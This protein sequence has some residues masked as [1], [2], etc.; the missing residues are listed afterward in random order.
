MTTETTTQVQ[1]R[2]AAKTNRTRIEGTVA[3]VLTLIWG[4]GMALV[5]PIGPL[6]LPPPLH[7]FQHLYLGILTLLT[8]AAFAVFL[9]KSR[10]GIAVGVITV[11]VGILF[12]GIAP[13]MPLFVHPPLHIEAML[14]SATVTVLLGLGGLGISLKKP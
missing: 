5:S 7:T 6:Y 9:R 2:T 1:T 13:G 3:S 4:I 12:A 10:A 11:I 14:A 8:G